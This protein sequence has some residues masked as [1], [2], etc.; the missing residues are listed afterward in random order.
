MR[1]VACCSCGGGA[2][3]MPAQGSLY[4]EQPYTDL[5]HD[6]YTRGVDP[7]THARRLIAQLK[8][9]SGKKIIL[10]DHDDDGDRP[11][12]GSSSDGESGEAAD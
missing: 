9:V 12:S 3:E 11:D 1:A 2:S 7:H 8:A 10:V 4:A 5:G 6:Y